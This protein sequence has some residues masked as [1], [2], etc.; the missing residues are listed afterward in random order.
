MIRFSDN[1]IN[2]K[3]FRQYALLLSSK[4]GLVVIGFVSSYLLTKYM[5]IDEYG[6]YKYTLNAVSTISL[7]SLL[8]IPYSAS[9][10]SIKADSKKHISTIASSAIILITALYIIVSIILILSLFFLDSIGVKNEQTIYF[11]TFMAITISLQSC[12]ITMYQGSNDIKTIS[13]QTILPPLL[14]AISF[15][16]IG[17]CFHNISYTIAITVFFLGYMFAHAF[18]IYKKKIHL[19]ST[20]KESVKSLL[21]IVKEKGLSVYYGSLIGV[22]SSYLLN[23]VLGYVI[24]MENYATYGLGLTMASPIQHIPSVMGVVLFSKSARS[25]LLSRSNIV[26]TVMMTL[27]STICYCIAIYF[28]F[29]Y[30]FPPKYGHSFDYVVL[31]SL[32]YALYGLGDYFNKFISAHGYSHYI[33]T[34]ATVSGIANLIFSSI[35][36]IFLKETG[37]ILGRIVSGL[38]YLITM[39]L[40]YKKLVFIM[41][42]GD[43]DHVKNNDCI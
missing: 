14:I 30:L 40:Y 13:A 8:G 19:S 22:G 15:G 6:M 38:L 41:K 9:L 23:M 5:S 3:V 7:I 36:I 11:A 31:L 37:L 42:E 18:T 26:K 28:A 34:G 12:F 39:V 21:Y 2:N 1:F 43:K 24:T 10:A 4:I 25:K 33:R 29:I 17:F 16:A 27:G 32:A 20:K 35:G